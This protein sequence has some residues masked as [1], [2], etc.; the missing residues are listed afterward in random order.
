M[1]RRAWKA[2][3]ADMANLM[4]LKKVEGENSL[5]PLS[6]LS[7]SREENCMFIREICS[8]SQCMALFRCSAQSQP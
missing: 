7:C 2:M 6:F 3:Y 1:N 8:S 5:M 4:F